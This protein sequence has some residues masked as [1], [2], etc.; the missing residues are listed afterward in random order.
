MRI[1]LTANGE[2]FGGALYEHP[3]ADDF[4]RLLPLELPFKDFNNVEKVAPL[5]HALTLRG[6]PDADEPVARELG[7]YAPGGN[8]V[9]Y[10]DSPGR[11]PG[12]VRLGYFTWDLRQLRAMPDGTIVRIEQ[13]PSPVSPHATP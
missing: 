2:R 13:D 10:Y 5:G 11:W 12:L 4:A 3:V 6:V 9:L 7:Y 1:I 8:L